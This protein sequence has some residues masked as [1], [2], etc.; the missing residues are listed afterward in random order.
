[1]HRDTRHGGTRLLARSRGR[2]DRHKGDDAGVTLPE[3]LVGIVM[4]AISSAI[5]VVVRQVD[6]TEGR[7]NNARSENQ[8]SLWMPGD[9]ASAAVDPSTN[10]LVNTDPATSPCFGACPEGF[11]VIGSNALLLQ[12]RVAGSLPDADGNVIYRE[13]TRVSYRFAL[14][15]EEYVLWSSEEFGFVRL[16]DRYSTGSSMLP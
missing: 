3:L 9:L 8:V 11:E 5:I 6:N 7:L 13:Q 14:I 4:A 16:D 10:K 15:G 2:R 12:W 1:M